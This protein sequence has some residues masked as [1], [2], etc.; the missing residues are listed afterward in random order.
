MFS[1]RSNVFAVPL[2]TPIFFGRPRGD[3]Q[4][5][6]VGP[7]LTLGHHQSVVVRI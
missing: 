7:G 3:L 4:L 6:C 1:L 2:N 5:F